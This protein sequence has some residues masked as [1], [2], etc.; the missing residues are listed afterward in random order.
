MLLDVIDAHPDRQREP[1][2]VVALGPGHRHLQ[3]DPEHPSGFGAAFVSGGHGDRHRLSLGFLGA[4]A[5]HHGAELQG[6]LGLFPF[7]FL[8]LLFG[9]FAHTGGSGTK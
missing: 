7:L 5:H 1:E 8:A 4:R 6:L 9:F 3:G 2:A